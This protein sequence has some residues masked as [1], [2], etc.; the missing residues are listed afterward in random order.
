MWL[1]FLKEACVT[2]DLY[3]HHQKCSNLQIISVFTVSTI[4]GVILVIFSKENMPFKPA[5]GLWGSE[6]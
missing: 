4:N 6:C 3:E 5:D 1:F 2:H